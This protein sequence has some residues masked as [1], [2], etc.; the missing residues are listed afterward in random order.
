V[1]EAAEAALHKVMLAAE[2]CRCRPPAPKGEGGPAM[3]QARDTQLE[4]VGSP[5]HPV[6]GRPPADE[7]L[8]QKASAIGSVCTGYSLLGCLQRG[9]PVVPRV[10]VRHRSV[11]LVPSERQAA[12]YR[13]RPPQTPRGPLMLAPFRSQNADYCYAQPAVAHHE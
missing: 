5:P 9:T 13:P 11:P 3:A 8:S 2:F 10:T 6:S 7:R 12:A 1:Y 4:G